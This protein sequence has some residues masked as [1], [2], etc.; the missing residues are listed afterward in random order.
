M[1]FLE[2]IGPGK[3]LFYGLA[4]GFVIGCL[5]TAWIAGSKP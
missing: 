1:S 2:F 5:V 4:V 3:S